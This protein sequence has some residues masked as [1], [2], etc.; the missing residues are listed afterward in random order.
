MERDAALTGV[1]VPEG[2]LTYDA[3]VRGAERTCTRPVR[4]LVDPVALRF[5]DVPG[6]RDVL[7]TTL[8]LLPA[9]DLSEVA[10]DLLVIE[11]ASGQLLRSRLKL[12][13]VRDVAG[14][15]LVDER[16]DRVFL[17]SL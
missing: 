6:A 12:L 13:P 9:P 3:P 10:R 11:I 5:A 17:R 15:E 2:L 16:L 14:G 8:E 7:E 1:A 4:D